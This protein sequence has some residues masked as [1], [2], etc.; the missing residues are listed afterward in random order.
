MQK[1]EITEHSE[2]ES[3]KHDDSESSKQDDPIQMST[4]TLI[5]KF[6]ANLI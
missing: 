2:S 1:E 5:Q 6:V 4:R 3:N